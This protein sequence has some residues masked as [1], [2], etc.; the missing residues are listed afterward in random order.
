M[1]RASLPVPDGSQKRPARTVLETA[2]PYQPIPHPYRARTTRTVGAVQAP[3]PPVPSPTRRYRVRALAGYLA[4]A[5]KHIG[6][7]VAVVE[8]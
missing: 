6:G 7:N 2:H 1:S 4:E 5:A 8:V 3:V